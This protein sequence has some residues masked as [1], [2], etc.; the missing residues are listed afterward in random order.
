MNTKE[1]VLRQAV[2]NLI[3]QKGRHNTGIAYDR[4]VEVYTSISTSES[5]NTV[6][7]PVASAMQQFN[8]CDGGSEGDP[9]ERLRF[10]CSLAMCG[11]DWFDV[12]P[13]FDAIKEKPLDTAP[14]QPESEITYAHKSDPKGYRF[15]QS[16]KV[17]VPEWAVDIQPVAALSSAAQGEQTFDQWWDTNEKQFAADSCHMSEY[18]MASVVW[19]AARASRTAPPSDKVLVPVTQLQRWKEELSPFWFS[20]DG[21]EEYNNDGVIDTCQEIDELIADFKPNTAPA[22]KGEIQGEI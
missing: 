7:Q 14:V 6:E 2:G 17:A 4:L 10:F 21:E 1:E 13:F 11:R 15:R 12:E 16:S 5:S 8:A 22:D 9:V 3:K 19:D 18:H 20:S